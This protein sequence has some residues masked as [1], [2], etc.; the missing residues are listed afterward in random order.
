[1]A[2]AKVEKFWLGTVPATDDFGAPIDN[3]FVDGKTKMGPW[4][5]MAPP[6]YYRYGMGLGLGR[7]QRYRKRGD[8]KWLKTAG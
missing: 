1:M 4:G 6:S 3:E 8:G 7:G 5:F 2:K